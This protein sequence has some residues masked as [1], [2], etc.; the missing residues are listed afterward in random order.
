MANKKL[1]VS[2]ESRVQKIPKTGLFNPP[3]IEHPKSV[4]YIYIPIIAV[5][6]IY[7]LLALQISWY[8]YLVAF[9]GS[10]AFWSAFEYFLHRFVL[11]ANP[12]NKYL[13]QF[14]YKTHW[15]HHEYPSDNRFVLMSPAVSLA[16]GV[17]FFIVCRLLF[18]PVYCFP[19]LASLITIY[20]AYEWMHY[21]AHNYNF[22]NPLFQKLKRHHLLHHFKDNEK[23]FGFITTQWDELTGTSFNEPANK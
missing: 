22:K 4:Y 11:H 21:A 1:Y 23:G 14:L 15:I 9:V 19:V 12:K 6:F 20:V 10:L 5:L 3:L 16:G 7:S 8:I 18:G 2:K 13:R 17:L